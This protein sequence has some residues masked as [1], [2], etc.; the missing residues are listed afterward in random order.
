MRQRV[1]FIRSAKVFSSATGREIVVEAGTWADVEMGGGPLT[2]KNCWYR[3]Y[4]EGRDRNGYEPYIRVDRLHRATKHAEPFYRL[5]DDCHGS[6]KT[7]HIRFPGL[8][9]R[10]FVSDP[11]ACPGC[12]GKGH[13]KEYPATSQ[14]A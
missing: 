6:G 14:A 7:Q 2:G 3:V 5:C 13:T 9:E 11:V 4:I 8:R 12:S 1:T 10:Q